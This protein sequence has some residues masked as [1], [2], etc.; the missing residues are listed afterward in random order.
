MN[1]KEALKDTSTHNP[2]YTEP[3]RWPDSPSKPAIPHQL[4]S[5]PEE[6]HPNRACRAALFPN[7][8]QHWMRSWDGWIAVERTGI[9]DILAIVTPTYNSKY[10]I[11][12]LSSQGWKDF[13][14]LKEQNT[15]MWRAIERCCSFPKG[16]THTYIIKKKS[17]KKSILLLHY[18]FETK[19]RLLW[20]LWDQPEDKYAAALFQSDCLKKILLLS[21]REEQKLKTNIFWKA[22]ENSKQSVRLSQRLHREQQ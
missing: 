10:K 17:Q 3:H 12:I 19:A 13:V 21:T 20:G 9:F 6:N 18:V 5:Y 22:G 7:I 8:T 2:T 16:Q 14:S 15:R 1:Y 4:P 11:L